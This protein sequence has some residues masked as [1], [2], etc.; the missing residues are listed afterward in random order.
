MQVRD[1][2]MQQEKLL[3]TYVSGSLPEG[4]FMPGLPTDSSPV[5]LPKVVAEAYIDAGVAAKVV[6]DKNA[7]PAANEVVIKNDKEIK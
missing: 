5:L 6:S 3:V 2:N 1:E 4:V 7:A